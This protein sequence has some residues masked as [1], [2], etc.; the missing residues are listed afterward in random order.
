M[1][2]IGATGSV[3]LCVVRSMVYR[4]MQRYNG[5]ATG[6]SGKGSGVI[7]GN[8]VNAVAPDVAVATLVGELL[9][10]GVVDGEVEGYHAIATANVGCGECVIA[11]LSVG[12]SMP[13]ETLAS[14][15][16]SITS[17]GWVDGEV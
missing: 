14:G 1:P 16:G 13:S 3:E 12:L 11:C 15:G 2:Q 10:N 8:G 17:S 7:S 6:S 9:E 4:K 5:V